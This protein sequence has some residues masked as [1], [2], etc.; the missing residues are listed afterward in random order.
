MLSRLLICFLVLFFSCKTSSVST[1]EL[2]Y[3]DV[4]QSIQSVVNKLNPSLVYLEIVI[5]GR[6]NKKS[7]IY[8]NGCFI[9]DKGHLITIPLLEDR[10][11]SISAWYKTKKYEAHLIKNYHN[12]GYSIV[13]FITPNKTEPIVFGDTALLERGSLIYGVNATGESLNFEPIANFGTISAIITQRSDIII[14]NGFPLYIH[15]RK[16]VSTLGMPIVNSKS[17]VI[18]FASRNLI[19]T[20]DEAKI[21]KEKFLQRDKKNYDNNKPWIGILLNT[22]SE[23]DSEALSIPRNGLRIVRVF[24][25]SPAEK[26]GVK[27]GDV[28]IGVNNQFFTKKN[29]GVFSQFR[30]WNDSKINERVKLHLLHRKRRV[31]A[32]VLYRKIPKA[33]IT[34]IN[35]LGFFIQEIRAQDYYDYQLSVKRG[36]LVNEVISGGIASGTYFDEDAVNS[37]D[38]IVEFEGVVVNSI[39]DFRQQLNEARKMEKKI[40]MLKIRDGKF[41]SYV[42]IKPKFR[43]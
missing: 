25:G 19:V 10:L 16:D 43:E 28:L 34:K 27:L 40:I 13:R 33:N 38:V 4:Q 12:L 21:V 20:N 7:T 5:E 23:D 15:N 22:I 1:V 37:G 31:V 35:E 2:F 29:E 32:D 3:N 6:N 26:A 8:A 18:G 14:H 9:D 17:E 24:Y 39:D 30:K 11:I 36:V 42:V 41:N